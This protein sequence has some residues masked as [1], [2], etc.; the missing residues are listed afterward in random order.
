MQWNFCTI[1]TDKAAIRALR[2]SVMLRL[3]KHSQIFFCIKFFLSYSYLLWI[4]TS[5][6]VYEVLFSLI[7]LGSRKHLHINDGYTYMT[8][9]GDLLLR[10]RFVLTCSFVLTC[11]SALFVVRRQACWVSQDAVSRV[12][13]TENQKARVRVPNFRLEKI[14]SLVS[15]VRFGEFFEF[16]TKT[17]IAKWVFRV[18][19]SGNFFYRNYHTFIAFFI[20]YTC[21][22]RTNPGNWN[23][24]KTFPSLAYKARIIAEREVIRQS[25]L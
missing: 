3:E 15:F 7:S 24:K 5:R 11:K 14:I 21:K 1:K 16:H 9:F 19:S 22:G 20:W 18:F 2:P 23:K 17:S 12:P 13:L 6:Y 10:R 25:I 4:F 8:L